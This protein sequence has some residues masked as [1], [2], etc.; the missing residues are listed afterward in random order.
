MTVRN[1]R[2]GR[3][4]RAVPYRA[5]ENLFAARSTLQRI[6]ARGR[7]RLPLRVER[8]DLM[9]YDKEE[10]R[11]LTLIVLADT[12]RSVHQYVE[13]F[14]QILQSMAGQF[15]RRRDRIGLVA[16]QG[17]QARILNH[18]THNHRVVTNS[19]RK[20]EIHGESPLA[21]G[22]QKAREMARIERFRNPSSHSVVVLISD[23]YPEPITHEHDDLFDEPAYRDSLRA[24]ALYRR[25]RVQ[26]LVINPSCEESGAPREKIG[27]GERLSEK[28]AGAASGRLLKLPRRASGKGV[29]SAELDRIFRGVESLL[30]GHLSEGREQPGTSSLWR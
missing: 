6:A 19:L 12:S 25:E 3:D 16:L 18:P 29:S 20:L 17:R 4:I 30:S 23:C 8:S 10:R 14:R 26:L 2:V 1:A 22:L 11:S 15:R 13:V 24:A 9:G 5:G 27:P 7:L 21:D 28:L